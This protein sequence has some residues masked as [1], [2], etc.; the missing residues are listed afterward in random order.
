MGE[1]VDRNRA[2][3]RL[4]EP[5]DEQA[6]VHIITDSFYVTTKDLFVGRFVPRR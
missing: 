4:I 2:R 1:S 6:V 5:T 3:T